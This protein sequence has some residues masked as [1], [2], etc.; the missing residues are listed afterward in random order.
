MFE[1]SLLYLYDSTE[2]WIPKPPD[3]SPRDYV[4]D[5]S[6]TTLWIMDEIREDAAEDTWSL[7]EESYDQKENAILLHRNARKIELDRKDSPYV[8]LRDFQ[9]NIT[10][11]INFETESDMDIPAYTV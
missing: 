4:K 3:P 2:P 1:S 10:F 9:I 5:G 6:Q 8:T 11:T 7:I